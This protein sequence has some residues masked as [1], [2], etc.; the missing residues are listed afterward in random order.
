M[1]GIVV[2]AVFLALGAMSLRRWSQRQL[3][4]HMDAPIHFEALSGRGHMNRPWFGPYQSVPGTKWAYIGPRSY[5]LLVSSL[6]RLWKQNQLAAVMMWTSFAVVFPTALAFFLLYSTSTASWLLGVV[7]A[8]QLWSFEENGLLGAGN[9]LAVLLVALAYVVPSGPLAWLLLGLAVDLRVIPLL[10]LPCVWAIH[11]P[12]FA[13]WATFVGGLMVL[14][15]AAD[16]AGFGHDPWRKLWRLAKALEFGRYRKHTALTKRPAYPVY[17]LLLLPWPTLCGVVS[18][19]WVVYVV[20]FIETP[21][22][23]RSG[24]CLGLSFAMPESWHEDW[25]D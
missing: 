4:T 16:V 21:W 12:G 14:R 17:F 25:S 22:G 7:L 24:G 18:L 8:V 3:A 6:G 13:E 1:D 2:A 10:F 9:P 20:C 5:L 23:T 15:I 11:P 19:A